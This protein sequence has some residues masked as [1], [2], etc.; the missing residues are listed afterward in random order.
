MLLFQI[1]PHS[2]VP[3]YRQVMDQVR[4]HLAAGT[5]APGRQLPSIRELARSLAVNPATIV[6]AYSELAHLNIIEIRHGRGAFI[7]PDPPVMPAD[8]RRAR[9]RQLTNQLVVEA[10]QLG[11]G[12]KEI[13]DALEQT[14]NEINPEPPET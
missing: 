2:G 14:L 1:D 4:Y 11:A 5:L 7:H 10:R 12:E 3:V 6:K 13:R 9:L 8:E